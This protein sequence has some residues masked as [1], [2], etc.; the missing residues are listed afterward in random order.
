LTYQLREAKSSLLKLQIPKMDRDIEQIV[1]L[2]VAQAF[3][4]H[5]PTKSQTRKGIRAWARLRW[6]L[7]I[8]N[9]WLR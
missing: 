7:W 8:A 4:E 6:R 2:Y 1:T 3:R 5:P 9:R